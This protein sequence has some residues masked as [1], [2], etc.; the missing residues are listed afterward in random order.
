MKR[1]ST[2]RLKAACLILAGGEGRRLTPD[3]PLLVIEGKAIIERVTSVVHSIFEEV[4][5]VT[6]TPD[7]FR[8]LNLPHVRDERPGCG[9]LMGIYSGLSRIEQ[10][11]AFVCAADM[12][13]LNEEIIRIQF[14][15]IEDYDMVVPSPGGLPEFLHAYY[16][17]GCL[18]AIKKN[19]DAG[20]YKIESVEEYCR[21]RR[22]N[23]DWFV[24]NGL[25][26]LTELAFANVNTLHDY[27]NLKRQ[28]SQN[29]LQNG[30]MNDPFDGKIEEPDI[31]KTLKPVVVKKIRKT[32]V[33]QES[34]YQ[35]KSANAEFSSLWAHSERVGRIAHHLAVKEGVDATASLLTGLLHDVG[36]FFDGK[37]HEDD[38]S[39]EEVAAGLAEHLLSGTVYEDLIPAIQEAVLSLYKEETSANEIGCVVYDADRLDKLGYM[40][41]AQFFAKNALRRHF[42][43]KDLIL[44]ASV[45]LTYAYHAKDT[46]KTVAGRDLAVVRGEKTQSYYRGLLEE[47]ET[48]GLGRFQICEEDIEGIVCVLVIPLSCGCGARFRVESDIRESVKC[49]SAVVQYECLQCRSQHEFSF[50]LPNIKGLNSTREK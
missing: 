26:G 49:R 5:L 29:G 1:S 37:H 27:E 42:L 3:K 40:G 38:V 17:R 16:R 39:E 48:L 36:K 6:N 10:D 12:P 31:L 46:L 34:A 8:F 21:A 13:F 23:T 14:Q 30:Q 15:E 44:R 19:L 33:E 41:V 24:R 7:K 2:T 22:L 4:L 28:H 35:R 20:R 11:V 32:L 50:C 45:E 43:D 9:P 25:N 18:P 47:W